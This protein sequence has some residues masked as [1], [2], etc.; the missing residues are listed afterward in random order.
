[1]PLVWPHRRST[2]RCVLPVLVGPSTAVIRLLPLL[3]G[4]AMNRFTRQIW[5][6]AGAAARA[7][8]N[9]TRNNQDLGPAGP[10]VAGDAAATPSCTACAV[11]HG[12]EG[13]TSESAAQV[14]V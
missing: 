10:P 3:A 13:D 7:C 14:T 1:M 12:H 5:S 11:V 4:E 2:A 6:A 8:G 9:R